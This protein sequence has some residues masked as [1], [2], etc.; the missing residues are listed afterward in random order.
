MT[1]DFAVDVWLHH[2][3]GTTPNLK[4]LLFTQAFVL[5]NQSDCS[6]TPRGQPITAVG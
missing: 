6:F 5:S 2:G 3:T 1:S 4:C